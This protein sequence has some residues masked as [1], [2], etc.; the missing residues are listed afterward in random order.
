VLPA[1]YF[2]NLNNFQPEPNAA[3]LLVW[4]SLPLSTTLDKPDQTAVFWN[5]RDLDL[6]RAVARSDQ[7]IATLVSRLVNI[8]D[9]LVQEGN[10]RAGFFAPNQA[11]KIIN[12]ALD[13]TGD[14]FFVA[15]LGTERDLVEGAAE[16]LKDI[17]DALSSAATAPTRAIR[18][19]SDF[20]STITDTFHNQLSNTYDDRT[21]T[22][23]RILGPMLLVEASRALRFGRTSPAAMLNLYALKPGHKFQLGSYVKGQMPPEAEVALTQTLVS[24]R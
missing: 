21:G 14:G 15:L 4:S 16:A 1:L 22:T 2:Q 12:D 11:Q 23:S 3:A 18:K 13:T 17:T 20:A 7:T 19:L 6:R 8:H 9:V 10:S 5:F 24:L